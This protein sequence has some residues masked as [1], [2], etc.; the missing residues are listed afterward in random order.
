MMLEAI[1]LI[2]R[3]GSLIPIADNTSML[4]ISITPSTDWNLIWATLFLGLCALAAP[5]IAKWIEYNM[6]APK[7]ETS[8]NLAPPYCHIT[9]YTSGESVYYFRLRIDNKGKAQAKRCEVVLEKIWIIENETPREFPNFSPVNLIWVAGSAGTR[10]Q[11][12]D[13]NPRRSFFCDIGHIS[14]PQHQMTEELNHRIYLPGG[15]RNHLCFTLELLQIFNAQPNCLHPGRY[16]IE[17]GLY[18]ENAEYRKICLEIS[19][20]GVW[21]D[22]EIEMFREIH[23]RQIGNDWY[24]G[25]ED[26]LYDMVDRDRN[27]DKA[28]IALTPYRE[29]G[30]RLVARNTYEND[31]SLEELPQTRH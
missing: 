13:I 6:Y 3:T 1:Y 27:A 11:Y 25:Y 21:K 29:A 26:P 23:I 15:R 5:P 31:S 22:I 16:I 17:V 12:I 30:P 20:S 4:D 28:A 18:P 2:A 24:P 7:L 9:R 10:S 8:F 14:S 19:W